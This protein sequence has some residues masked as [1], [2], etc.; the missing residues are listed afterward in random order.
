[1]LSHRVGIALLLEKGGE[2]NKAELVG[3]DR[4]ALPRRGRR[5]GRQPRRG[6]RPTVARQQRH[7]GSGAAATSAGAA[8]AAAGAA[9]GATG[10]RA[11]AAGRRA[12]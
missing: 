11:A 6:A 3:G 4:P 9:G 5:R 10:G 7:F 1:M 2:F 8:T 12:R